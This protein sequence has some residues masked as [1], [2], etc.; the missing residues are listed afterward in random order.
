RAP[1]RAAPTARGPRTRSRARRP[2][3]RRS[4]RSCRLL[5]SRMCRL[6]A[7]Q[8]PQ[9]L[10]ARP[11]AERPEVL[12]VAARR[13]PAADQAFHGLVQLLRR[14]APEDRP[15][16]R[17]L[18]SE[19]A[20]QEHVVGLAPATL[21]VAYRRA[22]EAEVAGP[23]L[24]AGVRAA[25]EVEPEAGDVIAEPIL[26]VPEERVGA[27]LRLGDGEVAVRLAGAGDRDGA[28]PVGIQWEADLGEPADRVVDPRLRNVGDDEVLLPGHPDV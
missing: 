8:D 12:A 17:R 19:S 22:L 27:R 13:E 7:D 1:T 20:A 23:V 3:D 18:R 2:R 14:Y 9:L 21:L 24:G 5:L 16:D 28:D 4:G 26:E 15:G 10:V 25:V 11:V 6:P